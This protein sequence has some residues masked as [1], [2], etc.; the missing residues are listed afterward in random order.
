MNLND[1]ILSRLRSLKL[2]QSS[3]QSIVPSHWEILN[4]VS[5]QLCI[6]SIV[7]LLEI[8][9]SSDLRL[10]SLCNC[11]WLSFAI[12]SSDF[13]V[14]SFGFLVLSS[15]KTLLVFVVSSSK[16]VFLFFVLDRSWNNQIDVD[17]LIDTD[18]FISESTFLNR[19]CRSNR[20]SH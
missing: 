3:L 11:A 14:F 7:Y 15:K 9:N 6:L 8:K 5:S 13:L 1:Q 18:R 16:F 4:C 20:G 19:H 2:N 12:S 17:R 10:N